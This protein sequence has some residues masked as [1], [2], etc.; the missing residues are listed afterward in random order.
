MTSQR[1]GKST[2][3][4]PICMVHSTL[5]PAMG[6]SSTVTNRIASLNKA[7][8]KLSDCMHV[9]HIKNCMWSKLLW[10]SHT[11]PYSWCK[12]KSPPGRV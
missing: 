3:G 8:D 9:D 11:N 4:I 10:P 12:S 2:P 6:F 5:R 1:Y 7:K